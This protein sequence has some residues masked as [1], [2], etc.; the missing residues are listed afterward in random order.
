MENLAKYLVT[1]KEY[2]TKTMIKNAVELGVDLEYKE[3]NISV[4]KAHL[5]SVPSLPI[6]RGI[7]WFVNFII[8]FFTL[9]LSCYIY[10]LH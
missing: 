3:N 8:Y 10:F 1:R 6:I 9:T 4:L 7:I 5:G 2:L